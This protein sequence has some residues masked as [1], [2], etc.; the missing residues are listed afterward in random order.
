MNLGIIAA[1][2]YGILVIIGGIIGYIQ[3]KSKVSL[4]SGSI[5]GLLI[6]LAAYGQLQGISWGLIVAG[7]ITAMLVTLFAVRLAKT[8]KFIPAGLMVIF[9]A[10]TLVIII[11]QI[12]SPQ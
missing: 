6:I 3:V 4:V 7:L 8:R 12:L 5:S 11:N 2:G 9:G 1:F 10:V